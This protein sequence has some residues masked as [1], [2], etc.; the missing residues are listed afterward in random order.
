MHRVLRQRKGAQRADPGAHLLPFLQRPGKLG[1]IRLNEGDVPRPARAA[2]ANVGSTHVRE[3]LAVVVDV[4][5][6]RPDYLALG[7]AQVLVDGVEEVVVHRVDE[8]EPP[9]LGRDVAVLVGVFVHRKA[10]NIVTRHAELVDHVR[11]FPIERHGVGQDQHDPLARLGGHLDAV[12]HV[13]DEREP[14]LL[15]RHHHDV[16]VRVRMLVDILALDR[17]AAGQRF[18]ITK[19]HM[20]RRV[21][22][23]GSHG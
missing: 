9:S 7:R 17:P 19:R 2:I 22:I 3:H 12:E 20:G 14:D 8:P 18:L 21:E 4:G 23:K 1:R 13:G 15:A 10:V 5:V 6:V 11:H 16:E